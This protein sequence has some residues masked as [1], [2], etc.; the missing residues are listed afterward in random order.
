MR[1]VLTLFFGLM[2][3]CAPKVLEVEP[4][5]PL[6][7]EDM[8]GVMSLLSLETIGHACPVEGKVYTAKHNTYNPKTGR[9]LARGFS[10][11]DGLGN[12]GVAHTELGNNYYD[13][14]TLF[15]PL[16]TPYYY[17]RGED[18][19]RGDR[20]RWVEFEKDKEKV[21]E[22]RVVT[23]KVIHSIAGYIFLDKLPVPGAS[24]SC[25]ID[26]SGKAV[27]M[28]VWGIYNVAGVA[29]ELP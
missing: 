25:L 21:F 24:G 19:E 17:E 7:D 16:G 14:A 18:L 13:V 4:P 26:E 20:V 23:A 3:C 10:W 6:P 2:L 27:G 5:A 12:K 9:V 29:V 22:Q 8:R 15:V 28:V 1:L 11:E